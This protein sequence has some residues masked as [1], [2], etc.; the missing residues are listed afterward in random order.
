MTNVVRSGLA[1]AWSL[2]LAGTL[3]MTAPDQAPAAPPKPATAQSQTVP[4]TAVPKRTWTPTHVLPF[5]CAQAWVEGGR[6]YSGLYSVVETLARVSLAN[7]DLTFP[8]TKE[9]GL[10]AGNGIAADCKADPDALLFAIVDRH[11]RRVSTAA[12]TPQK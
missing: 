10:D 6:T 3:G 9:A 5:T 4:A 11:V 12:S 8:D 1:G 7:R 2:A